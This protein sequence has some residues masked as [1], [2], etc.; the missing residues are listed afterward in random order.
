M[1]A[2]PTIEVNLPWAPSVNH[3]YKKTRNGS[4]YLSQQGRSFR[5]AVSQILRSCSPLLLEGDLGVHI[6][7]YP[8]DK[9]KRDIDNVLK[10]LLDALEHGG[11]YKDDSQ[12]IYLT[13]SKNEVEK[14]G[15]INVKIMSQNS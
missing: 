9:R 14:H 15:K 2:T 1:P 10:A 13:V 8:P 7:L 12:I 4:F 11:A 3:Y 5:E 6:K